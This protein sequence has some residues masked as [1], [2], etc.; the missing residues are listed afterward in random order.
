MHLGPSEL[1]LNRD[2]SV[3]HLN[4]LPGDIADTVILVG[5][6]Q[7]VERVSKHFDSLEVEKQKREFI[8]HT[9]WYKGK[10]ISVISTG[11]GTDNIDIVLN[12]LDALVNID[13]ND[14]NVFKD[15]TLLN[16]IRIG[17]SGAV[18]PEIPV[19]TFLLSEYVMGFDSVLYYYEGHDAVRIKDME[20]AFV[21]HS[22]WDDLKSQPYIV[23]SDNTLLKLLSGDEVLLG[24]TGSNVGF[25]GPQARHL[26]LPPADSD[27]HKKLASF[28]YNGRKLTNF[29]METS[30]LYGL[31][32]LMG[33]RAISVNAIIAN[34]STHS[35][36]ADPSGT[37]D[38]LIAFTLDK[39]LQL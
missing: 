23:K 35:F 29:E 32:G 21:S 39:L 31:S 11:I 3:Y 4:L 17:T 13:L 28:E 8:T 30:A 18:Q 38:K 1:I 19:D 6:P 2:G 14:R 25:Y 9:G 22:G 15:R 16:F 27:L 36:S 34:R 7:R 20:S 26:R 33:H 12:E 24:F 37:I 5:D 10:R